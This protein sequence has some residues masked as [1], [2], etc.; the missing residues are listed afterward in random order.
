MLNNKY[1]AIVLSLIVTL[2]FPFVT[3]AQVNS[4]DNLTCNDVKYKFELVNYYNLF[5]RIEY[6]WNLNIQNE[7]VS[8]L[9]IAETYLLNDEIVSNNLISYDENDLMPIIRS[10]YLR[11]VNNFNYDTLEIKLQVIVNSDYIFN[12]RSKV[13][14]NELSIKNVGSIYLPHLTN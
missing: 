2:I 10:D 12:C 4:T 5:N 1:Q 3:F 8:Y 6:S 9:Q 7:N 14:V 13:D 11:E